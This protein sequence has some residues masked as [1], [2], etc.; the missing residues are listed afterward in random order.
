MSHPAPHGHPAAAASEELPIWLRLPFDRIGFVLGPMLLI[1][2]LT[3]T[4]PGSLTP[5][6]H[7]LAGIMLLTIVWWITEPIPIFATGLLAIALC[8]VLSLCNL[9]T[10]RRDHH[11][12]IH[13]RVCF[14]AHLVLAMN[15]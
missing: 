3:L 4:E 12:S 8:V 13:T 6:A 14:A 11:T 2:W 9:Q 5:E 7:R 15:R 10:Y 1:G